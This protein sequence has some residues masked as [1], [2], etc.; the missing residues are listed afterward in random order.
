MTKEEFV[1]LLEELKNHETSEERK[2][3][4]EALLVAELR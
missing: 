4:I 3:E 1:K 2:Q